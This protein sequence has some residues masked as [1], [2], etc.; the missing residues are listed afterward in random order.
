MPVAAGVTESPGNQEEPGGSEL[1]S[2]GLAFLRRLKRE[3]D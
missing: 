1:P 2:S 3:R